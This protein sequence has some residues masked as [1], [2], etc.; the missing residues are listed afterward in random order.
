METVNFLAFLCFKSL[1]LQC[2]AQIKSMS[3]DRYTGAPFWDIPGFLK[4]T[5]LV[6]LIYKIID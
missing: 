5:K 1:P 2:T 6:P 3:R 4:H